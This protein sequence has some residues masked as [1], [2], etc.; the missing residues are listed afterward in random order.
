MQ[1]KKLENF[2]SKVESGKNYEQ[3]DTQLENYIPLLRTQN[4]RPIFIE[5]INTTFVDRTS[6]AK[7][8]NENDLLFVRVGVGVG[9]CCAITK[10]DVNLA[11][12]DNILRVTCHE[13]LSAQYVA[14]YLS[15]Y[16]GKSLLTRNIKGSGRPVIS[17]K[18]IEDILIPIPP[19]NI[20]RALINNVIIAYKLY[21]EK[22]EQANDMLSQ[23]R[24]KVF[25]T[26]GIHFEEYVPAL[27]SFTKLKN[28]LEIGIYCN[29]HSDYLNCVFSH[30]RE[31]EFYA[32]V[33][34]DFVEINPTTS[35]EG[36]HDST[37]VSFVPMPAVEEKTNNVIYEVKQYKEVKN[38][39]TIFQKNDLLWA[40]ITPCM[41]NGKSFIAS[42]MPTQIGF[43]STEFHVLRKKDERIYMPYLWVILS[44]SHILEAAQ[45][46]FSGSAGQQRVSDGFLKKF[47]I[48]LP[49]LEIQK[50][51]ANNVFD[52]LKTN[53]ITRVQAEHDWQAAKEQF[54]KEL[55]GE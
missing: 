26:L 43:G 52:V 10:K 31:N 36:L 55:L 35:R 11:F 32:G 2:I 9:D 53:K 49:P 44:D 28:L 47:P 8:T 46:M 14:I 29:P 24:T 23:S 33:L 51:L 22:I 25:E 54:E 5:N 7:L 20:E 6:V 37:S 34:E 21:K 40:K 16:I 1:F 19:K 38:G 41:Q 13:K 27:Y 17:R 48:I 12:S 50:E 3:S 39:F 42:N 45:G 15:S 4:V 30:L 18:S